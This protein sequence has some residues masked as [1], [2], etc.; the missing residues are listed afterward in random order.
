MEKDCLMTVKVTL[1]NGT[2]EIFRTEKY[3]VSSAKDFHP[4]IIKVEIFDNGK[5]IAKRKRAFSFWYRRFTFT[6]YKVQ[7]KLKELQEI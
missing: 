1:A 5:R 2:I 3:N 4:L 6:S 7:H